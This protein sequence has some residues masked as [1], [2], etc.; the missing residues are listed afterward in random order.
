MLDDTG[1]GF[2]VAALEKVS[3]MGLNIFLQIYGWPGDEESIPAI[4]A[5]L[6]ELPGVQGILFNGSDLPGFPEHKAL[7][8]SE[9]DRLGVPVVTIDLFEQQRKPL[10]SLV[11]TSSKKEVIRLHTI[12]QEERDL[13]TKER[14]LSRYLLAATER[15]NRLLLVRYQGNNL[16]GEQWLEE[17]T[18]FVADLKERLA[19]AGHS[20]GRVTPYTSTD[21][22][23]SRVKIF[24]ISM[25]ILAGG[26]LLFLRL[27]APRTGL[28]LGA[29]GLLL[30]GVLLTVEGKFM[31]IDGIDLARKGM[32]LASGIIFP[33][34]G[35]VVYRNRFG[36]KSLLKAFYGLLAISAVSLA[37]ALLSVG[38]LAGMTYMVKLDQLQGI[39]IALLLPLLLA[40][41]LLI[42]GDEI[43]MRSITRKMRD[44]WNRPLVASSFLPFYSFLLRLLS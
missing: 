10:L 20:A 32:A 40:G 17:N 2:P 9:V 24:L 3:A 18:G 22:T 28:L 13:L 42:I 39:R 6:Q 30:V 4:F 7:T 43:S 15:N 29:A 14:A 26:A 37:G 36:E 41:L 38:L 8:A 33:L 23:F 5:A 34:L 27:G 12:P 16:Y 35:L 1:V 31:G 19:A 44:L 11:R 21:F 25:G